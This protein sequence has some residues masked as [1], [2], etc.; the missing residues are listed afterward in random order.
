MANVLFVCTAN[1]CRSAAAEAIARA[2]DPDVHVYASA[3]F[4]FEGHPV[5][6]EMGRALADIG[7]DASDHSSHIIN[8]R[9][10]AWADLVLTM[11]SRHLQDIAIMSPEAFGHTIPLREAAEMLTNWR[12]TVDAFV[13]SLEGRRAQAYLGA[14]W[15]IDDPYKR[16]R[17][18]YRQSVAEVSDLVTGVVASLT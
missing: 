15:D 6:D 18:T 4:L 17:R 5:D 9:A 11:E 12:T 13:E 14:H 16:S 1:I 2:K 7:I 10:V 3:G 8:E